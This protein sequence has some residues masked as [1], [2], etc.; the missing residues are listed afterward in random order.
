MAPITLRYP[1]RMA[2]L[3]GETLVF[4]Q[5]VVRFVGRL[6]IH[7]K[8]PAIHLAVEDCLAV[9]F[10]EIVYW[11]PLFAESDRLSLFPR[12]PLVEKGQSVCQCIRA[13]NHGKFRGMACLTGDVG[14]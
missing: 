8:G 10:L 12:D 1:G 9:L 4:L 11:C 3:A 13:L 2:G 5:T 7:L 14:L 6:G